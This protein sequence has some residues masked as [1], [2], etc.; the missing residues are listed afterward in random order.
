MDYILL[1]KPAPLCTARF[2]AR[3]GCKE[4]INS[5]GAKIPINDLDG[6]NVV[7]Y[8]SAVC[9]PCFAHCFLTPSTTTPQ[10]TPPTPHAH[11]Y[12]CT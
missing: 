12:T 8:V 7:F 6:K 10:P 4:L 1:L 9:A 5:K 11:T 3:V 2:L